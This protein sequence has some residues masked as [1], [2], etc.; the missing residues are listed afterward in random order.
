MTRNVQLVMLVHPKTSLHGQDHYSDQ[1]RSLRDLR[2]RVSQPSSQAHASPDIEAATAQTSTRHAAGAGGHVPPTLSDG[3][4]ASYWPSSPSRQTGQSQKSGLAIRVSNPQMEHLP[5]RVSAA[6]TE[7]TLSL[8]GSDVSDQSAP[9]SNRRRKNRRAPRKATRYALA[10]PAPQMRMKQRNFVQFR[11]RLLLQLQ[12]LGERR[13]IPAWDVIPSSSV[14]GSLLIPGLARRFP[15][16]FHAKKDLGPHDLLVVRSD[17]YEISG[18]FDKHE[19]KLQEKDIL[20][21]INFECRQEGPLFEIV[22]EDGSAWRASETATG[23]YDFTSTREDGSVAVARWAKRSVKS[24][25]SGV[26]SSRASSD[27]HEDKWTFSIID[28]STRIHPV[29][30]VLTATTLEVFDTYNTASSASGRRGP[31]AAQAPECRASCPPDRQAKQELGDDR[32]EAAAVSDEHKHL[33]MATA[34]WLSLRQQGWPATTI[35]KL[36]RAMSHCHAAN[37]ERSRRSLTF[38][39]TE[40]VRI[41]SGTSTPS[42][43]M[44]NGGTSGLSS[45][46]SSRD[47]GP[48]RAASTGAAFMAKRRSTSMSHETGRNGVGSERVAAAKGYPAADEAVNRSKGSLRQLVQR[49]FTSGGSKR[50]SPA[51]P[52]K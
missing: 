33:M 19:V 44:S 5:S 12:T 1:R 52:V 29:M 27:S 39:A 28:P 46:R 11:P 51:R 43:R 34:T 13:A 36:A 18:H 47:T 24:P 7:D 42:Q 25:S 41:G 3:W 50:R 23:S 40:D 22:L 48:R 4:L 21:V 17:D 35:P 2:V 10:Q 20:A 15:W 14:A 6:L 49:L 45:P 32:P 8:D 16:A 31:H 9:S 38:P 30:G 26:G 37:R